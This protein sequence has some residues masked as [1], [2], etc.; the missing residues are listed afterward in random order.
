MKE[1]LRTLCFVAVFLLTLGSQ[2]QEW[3][4]ISVHDMDAEWHFPYLIEHVPYFEFNEKLDTLRMYHYGADETDDNYIP[5][6]VSSLDSISFYSSSD[7]HTQDHYK[8][9]AMNIVT[10]NLSPVDSKDHYVPCYISIDGKGEFSDYSGSA[11]I[12]GRG[13]STWLWYPKKPYRIKLDVKDKILGLK[14]NKDWVLLANY[15]DPTDLMNTFA[16]ETAQWMGMP[17]TNH[18]RY[19]EVFLNTEYIGLYQLTEQVE[20]GSS[21]VDIAEEGGVLLSFDLDDGPDLSPS[22][23]DNFYSSVYKMP[24]CV[25]YPDDPTEE[26]IIQIRSELAELETAIKAHDYERVAELMDLPSFISM[27]QLQE[28]LYNVDFTAPRSVYMFRDAGGKYTMGP[29]WDWDAGYDFDW[30]SEHDFFTSY[31]KLMMGTD[32]L[33]QN[34]SY[35]LPKFF[36]DM[37]GSSRFVAEYKEEW[38]RIA[39]SVFFR[40]WEVCEQYVGNLNKGAFARD[41][42]RWSIGKTTATEIARMKTWL[43]NRANYMTEV[44]NAYPLPLE[45]T[46]VGKIKKTLSLRYAAGYSQ[47]VTVDI[48]RAELAGILGVAPASILNSDNLVIL[49]LMSDGSEGANKTNGV[50]GG[51]FDVNGEPDSWDSGHVYIEVFSDLFSWNCGVR[52]EAGYCVRGHEHTVTMQYQYRDVDSVK[53]VDVE[54]TF[55]VE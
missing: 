17:F 28:Y 8:V 53:A 22:A 46:V 25:K 47:S 1:F 54:V 33:H 43:H 30:G 48:D 27:L 6:P 34:G 10:D 7:T 14:K 5:L 49:P 38:S 41:S 16:F 20:Q 11:R 13:N 44:V 37:F 3:F 50:F 9:F 40:N 26:Q 42:R 2:S 23:T 51:W 29:V 4:R 31:R 19:V 24:M 45:K 55:M 18:T 52:A 21:R 39:S 35:S 12:R 15:R 32:P 36:T